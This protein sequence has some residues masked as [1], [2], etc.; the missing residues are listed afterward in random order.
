MP[1]YL[2]YHVVMPYEIGL[3]I[4]QIVFSSVGVVLLGICAAFLNKE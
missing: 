1:G 3:V 2:I 4:K